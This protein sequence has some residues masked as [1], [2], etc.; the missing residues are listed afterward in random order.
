ME[1]KVREVLFGPYQ[2]LYWQCSVS[3][4][5]CR[6]L[7]LGVLYVRQVPYLC[8]IAPAQV[9]FDKPVNLDYLDY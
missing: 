5:G 7:N 8:N 4:L 3:H 6:G 2:E 1:A 9:C